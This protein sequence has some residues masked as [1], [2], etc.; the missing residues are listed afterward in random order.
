MR[1]F[2]SAPVTRN[3]VQRSINLLRV[4]KLSVDGGAIVL[5]GTNEES[6]VILLRFESE[7][8]EA[9]RILAKAGIFTIT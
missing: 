3:K 8:E 2:L 7:S 9:I 5:N 6:G 4:A 1:L